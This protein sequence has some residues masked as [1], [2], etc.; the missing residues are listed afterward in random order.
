MGNQISNV[1]SKT[2]LDQRS[3]ISGST[4]AHTPKCGVGPAPAKAIRT[5][6]ELCSADGPLLAKRAV[7]GDF[8][9]GA[10]EHGEL[11]IV[12]SRNE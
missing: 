12:Q 1:F 2:W 6:F 4:K 3:L 7:E 5:G 10:L 11:L 9:Q 8:L